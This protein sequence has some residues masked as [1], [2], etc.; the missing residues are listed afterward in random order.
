MHLQ[1]PPRRDEQDPEYPLNEKIKV[2]EDKLKALPVDLESREKVD[3]LN[4]LAWELGLTDTKRAFSLSKDALK[5]SRKIDY[6]IGLAYGYRNLGYCQLISSQLE[7]GLQNAQNAMDR[8]K[9][10]N[11]KKGEATAM[12]TI[13]LIFWRLGHYD[14]ALNCSF[15][16]LDLNNEIKDKRGQA[17]ALQNIGLIYLEVG[18]KKLSLDFFDKS[19]KLFRKIGYLVGE[20]RVYTGLGQVYQNSGELEN[21][22]QFHLKSLGI[23]QTTQIKI[24]IAT[25]SIAIGT[26]YHKL[27]QFEQALEYFNNSLKQLEQFENKEIK[28]T[29]LLCLGNLY[30][31]HQDSSKAFEYLDEALSLIK[32]TKAKPTAFKIHEALSHLYESRKNFKK[33]LIHFKRYQKFKDSVYN[34]DSKIK[35]KNMQI[36]M[37]VEKSYKEA[38]IQRIKNIELA[39]SLEDLK[40]TQ[41]RL[42]QSE[43]MAALGSLVAGITHDMNSPLA[44]ITSNTDVIDRALTKIKRGFL[45]KEN[46]PIKLNKNLMQTLDIIKPNSESILQAGKRVEKIVNN[47]K[48][49]THSHEEELQITDLNYELEN[50]IALITPRLPENTEIIKEF[51]ALPK[52][53]V[54]HQELNQVFMT[55]LVNA[56]EAIRDK[57]TITIKT[58]T[59]NNHVTI[60]ISDT[61][62]GIAKNKLAKIFEVGFSQKES[63][64]QMNVGLASS[65]NIIQR[66]EGEIQVKSEV[67]KGTR[68]QIKLPVNLSD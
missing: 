66:H 56:A 36:R 27:G 62:K 54:Y 10:L 23:S 14:E 3:H 2:L 4:D 57:G 31:D 6:D 40:Q 47:L 37:H 46:Q 24:G 25:T 39:K 5:L 33:A 58:S 21:A 51:G 68:Y 32:Q 13:S 34:D 45:A 43:G 52:I 63:R 19:L 12:D 38:E 49:F 60:F 28:A 18:D 11:D 59:E 48:R 15:M 1:Q 44:V 8:F 64:V 41:A 29:T 35:V 53:K 65:Y 50:T 67:G 55:L 30:A 7:E 61:G 22:L 17:W 42:I 9:A 26:I 20:A 16:A